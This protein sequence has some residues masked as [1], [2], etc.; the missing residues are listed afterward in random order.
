MRNGL[1]HEIGILAATAA[2]STVSAVVFGAAR[3]TF[4]RAAG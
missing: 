2:Q 4:S 3:R 1:V